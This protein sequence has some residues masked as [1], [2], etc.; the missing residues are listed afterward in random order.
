MVKE[1][2]RREEEGGERKRDKVFSIVYKT[3]H[4]VCTW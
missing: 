2:E 4:S 1:E 3:Y